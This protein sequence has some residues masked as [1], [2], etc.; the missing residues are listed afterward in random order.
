MDCPARRGEPA[1]LCGHGVTRASGSSLSPLTGYNA[2]RRCLSSPWGRPAMF[3]VMCT[4]SLLLLGLA[5]AS[6]AD[7]PLLTPQ[8]KNH[9]AWKPP[10]RPSV[11]KVQ[12]SAWVRN[13][14]DAFVLARL[15][16]AGLEP[17]QAASPEQWLRRV[18]F[19]LIGLPP[20]PEELDSFVREIEAR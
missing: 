7:D 9:W 18:T 14:I 5:A 15:E 8:K 19:D 13:P 17:A 1:C 10:Q 4:V 16:A 3:R 6:A 12:D 11:P 2:S 20:T